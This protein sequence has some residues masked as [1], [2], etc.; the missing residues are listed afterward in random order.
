MIVTAGIR[1]LRLAFVLSLEIQSLCGEGIEG[2][3]YKKNEGE[4]KEFSKHITSLLLNSEGHNDCQ[5]CHS[6][7]I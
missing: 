5:N 6:T 7:C 2:Q 1:T 3:K 4:V